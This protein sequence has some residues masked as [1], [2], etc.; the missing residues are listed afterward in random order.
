MADATEAYNQTP[1][2]KAADKA[3]APDNRKGDPRVNL[4]WREIERY[5]RTVSDW[6]EEGEQIEKVYTNENRPDNSTTRKFAL[7]WSNVQT[8]QPAVYA[9]LPNILCS[10]RFKDR[11]VVGRV[12]AELLERATNTTFDIYGVDEVFRMV[13]DDRLL[14]GR[15]QAWVRYEA[16]IERYAET[17]PDD[18]DTADEAAPRERLAGERVCVDYVNWKDFGHNVAGTWKDVYLVWRC[19]YKT[20]DEV[21]ERFGAEK[22]STISYNAKLPSYGGSSPTDDPDQRCRI[23]ELWDKMRNT[24]SWMAEGQKTFLESGPPPINF[25]GGFPCPEPCYATKS[26]RSLIPKPDYVYYRDQAKEIN[27]L[28]EKIH[29]L[30]Q[31]LIVKGFIPG[32]PSTL[33]DPIEEALRDKS[34]VELFQ[35]VD[36]MTEW[37]ERGGAAKLIDWLPIDKVV[38]ALQAAIQARQQLIQDVYQITGISDILRGQTD[39]N[40]TLGAQELKAQTG[41]SR[42]RNTRDA[43]SRFTRDIGALVMEVVAEKFQPDTIAAMTGYRYQPQP[44]MQGAPMMQPGMPQPGM[45][46]QGMQQDQGPADQQDMVFDDRH[47]QLMRDDR[48][49]GFRIDVETD[50]TV[51]PDENAEKQAR[52]EFMDGIGGLL[53]KSIPVLQ[54]APEMAPFLGEAFQFTARGFRAGR[55]LEDVMERSFAQLQKRLV[56]QQQNPQPNPEVMKIQGE[57]QVEQQQAAAN[58]QLQ[59]QK[60]QTDAQLADKKITADA[61]AAMHKANTDAALTIRKQNLDNHAQIRKNDQAAI[62]QARDAAAKRMADRLKPSS[63]VQ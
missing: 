55:N 53:E 39:P 57:L 37:T 56:Q 22:A 20:Y 29:R 9:K 41:N 51:Q 49:R 60:Q 24:V 38:Q 17:E 19:V 59:Q 4:Y 35:P 12:T 31:W 52:V 11:D 5:K 32:G 8:L 16:T 7:L 21:E 48:M 25:H 15:G 63:R 45:P 23:Y 6:Q 18:S 46:Q 30:T 44:M 58:V 36:S 13:R 50:S 62:A 42:L 33:A 61:Q 54:A 34:N 43:I 40:E 1:A 47:I 27:D 3:A 28:T 2:P 10:R 14:P 26:S